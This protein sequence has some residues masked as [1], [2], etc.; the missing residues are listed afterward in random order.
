MAMQH[1]KD[2]DGVIR[3]ISE[4]NNGGGAGASW[5]IGDVKTNEIAKFEQGLLYQ[6]IFKKTNGYF[7]GL[8]AADDL[9]IRH[10]ECS[11]NEGYNDEGILVQGGFDGMSFWKRPMEK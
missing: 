11:A 4:D 8:N 5:L 9:I 10:L 1:G 3:I 2:I 7:S 6:N